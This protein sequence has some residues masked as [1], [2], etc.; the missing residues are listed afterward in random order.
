MNRW[1]IGGL[2]AVCVVAGS[3]LAAPARAQEKCPMLRPATLVRGV[4]RV[5]GEG[6]AWI[7]ASSWPPAWVGQDQALPLMVARDVSV[8]GTLIVSGRNRESGTAI[9][10]GKSGS[11]LRLR[12]ER[13]TLD[14]LGVK[15]PGVAAADLQRYS[16]HPVDAWF[17]AAGCYEIT[18][19]V[20][21]AQAV[22]YLDVQPPA[23]K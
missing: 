10:L 19:R 23:K 21:R 13:L 12:E 9:R 8:S 7:G 5:V 22:V 4:W 6:P 1:A 16:F 15:P 14:P 11:T 17:P 18:A 3:E 20:G 2:L